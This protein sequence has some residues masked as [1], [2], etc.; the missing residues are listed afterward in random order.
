MILGGIMQDFLVHQ[1][2]NFLV[3]QAA[4][5]LKPYLTVGAEK[6]VV[7][8]ARQYLGKLPDPTKKYVGWVVDS[9]A[10]SWGV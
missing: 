6:V 9:L 8:E 2:I 10:D 7:G 1:A 3:P 5:W 4:G